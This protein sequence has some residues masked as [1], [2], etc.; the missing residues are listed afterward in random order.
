MKK[1]EI[2]S[3]F[4]PLSST[5]K[6]GFEKIFSEDGKDEIFDRLE[7]IENEH[8][9]KVQ[10]S[11]LFTLSG[12]PSMSFGFFKYYWLIVPEKHTY[13]VS[14]IE[15][16]NSNYINDNYIISIE[17]LYWGIKRIYFDS[18]LYFGNITNGYKELSK[19]SE[20]E[21]ISFFKDKR[22]P[23]ETTKLRGKAIDFEYI[24]KEDRYLIS[25]MACKTY[26]ASEKDNENLKKQLIENHRLAISKGYTKPRVKDLL[27]D[28]FI[29]E[30][31]KKD[32]D[33]ISVATLFSAQEISEQIIETEK[34]I[35]LHYE[36]IA[37]R[38]N[39]SREK[40]ILNTKY[41]LSLVSDLDVY[42]A[43]SMRTKKDFIEMANTCEKIFKDKRII[44]YHLRYFDPTI[45]AANGHEDKGLIECLMVKASKVLIY[46]SGVKESYGKDAEAAMALSSGKPVIF[47]STDTNKA[48]FYKHIHPLTKLIDFNSGVANGAIVTFE[49]NQVIEILRRLFENDMEYEI[50]Q[51][52]NGYFR[53]KDK[54][55]NSVVRLQTNDEL[56]AKSFW[57]YFERKIIE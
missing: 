11:Q 37:K 3:K 55:T 8:L 36:K 43:T 34:D 32:A 48:D 21:L 5:N 56:L 42:V 4:E 7:N 38:F 30:Q 52:K 54:L 40:A 12:M 22:F 10:L 47:Y 57:N 49:I 16:Y 29:K 26:E 24:K 39:G 2:I 50:D 28:K 15:G 53:L 1:K 14:K 51:P 46:T 31:L 18:L 41:Y 27:D 17:H 20:K 9:S 44:D 6:K 33:N 35:E 25:E 23:T 45:S 19:K 13:R